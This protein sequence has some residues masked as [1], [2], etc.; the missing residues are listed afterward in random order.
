MLHSRIEQ[1]ENTGLRKE[2]GYC[3]LPGRSNF[4]IGIE[5]LAAQGYV[6]INVVLFLKL[7]LFLK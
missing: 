1:T 6:V 7:T 4:N 5:F 3:R 2:L